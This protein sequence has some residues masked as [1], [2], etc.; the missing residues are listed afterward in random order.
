M[1]SLSLHQCPNCGRQLNS[2]QSLKY[3]IVHNVCQCKHIC[4]HCGNLFDSNRNLNN[5]TQKG[6]C[7][8]QHKFKLVLKRDCNFP[9]IDN[10]LE[11]NQMSRKELIEENIRLKAENTIFRDH[12]QTVNNTVNIVVPP[13]FLKPDTFQQLIKTRPDL[14]HDALLKHPCDFI[15]YLIGETNCNPKLP[16]FNSVKIMNKKDPYAQISNGEKYV[17]ASKK[18]IIEQL[19]ENKRH[20]LQEYVDQHGDK[21]GEKILSRYQ[22][23]VDTLDDNSELKKDLEIDVACMLLNV[24]DVIGSDEWSRKLL[25]DLRSWD[26]YK[27]IIP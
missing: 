25:D 3:H 2:K 27:P 11:F 8:K 14:L 26:I 5:H 1:S 18:K 23:Y 9:E 20:I 22:R 6:I 12:P 7:I 15:T 17:Y 21:C 4:L 24:S 19:I 13:A 10:S 16:I